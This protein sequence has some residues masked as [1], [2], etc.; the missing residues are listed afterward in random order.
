[1]AVTTVQTLEQRAPAREAGERAPSGRL[2]SI[3]IVRGVVMILMAIDHVRVFSGVPAGGPT[4]GV[5]FTR[6]ITH[7]VAPAFIFLAGT[8][9]YLHGTKL[10]NRGQLARFL[11]TRGAWL[12]LLELTVIR[13]S[14]TFN[15]DFQHYL[16]AGVIWVIGCCMM[17]M[18]ALVYLPT[19]AI[20][21]IGVLII[22]GHNVM[23]FIAP[24]LGEAVTSNPVFTLLY[25]GGGF[26]LGA[27]GPPLVILY[28]IVPWIGVM[29]AGY[30][31]GVVM[32]RPEQQRRA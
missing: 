11:F 9:A 13:V 5:F 1:M 20:G 22:A 14:W 23:D 25:F 3:D 6:W 2:T 7:F 21:T 27:N 29:A 12:I 4:P 28:S 16:L 17:L 24:R 30:A 10:A 8:A 19:V 32:L 26:Q 31:F 18:A 15:F